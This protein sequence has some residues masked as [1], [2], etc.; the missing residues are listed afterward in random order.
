MPTHTHTNTHF[1]W[2]YGVFSEQT[3]RSVKTVPL[4][5]NHPE[6]QAGNHQHNKIYTTP[7]QQ[8]MT[9]VLVKRLG[10]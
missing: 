7:A 2:W 10:N 5:V 1:D 4:Y 9:A 3:F 8:H 6:S